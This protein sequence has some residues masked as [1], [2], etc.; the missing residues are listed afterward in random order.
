MSLVKT[1]SFDKTNGRHP[2][3]PRIVGSEIKAMTFPTDHTARPTRSH[4]NRRQ[5]L[6]QRALRKH[7]IPRPPAQASLLDTAMGKAP[8]PPRRMSPDEPATKQSGPMKF[9]CRVAGEA[10]I[11]NQHRERATR[12]K[13]SRRKQAKLS[14]DCEAIDLRMPTM[15]KRG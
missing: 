1:P 13:E 15:Y 10:N 3:E 11:P 5:D 8:R 4:W 6:A 12:G 9:R 7:G 2:R 14:R